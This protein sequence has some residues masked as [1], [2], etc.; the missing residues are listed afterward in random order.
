[1]T[2]RPVIDPTRALAALA[3]ALAA[4]PATAQTLALDWVDSAAAGTDLN[5]SGH[6]LGTKAVWPCGDVHA[7]APVYQP[8]V[9]RGGLRHV[10]PGL[11]GQIGRAHV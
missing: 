2:R 9:W 6:V 4:L 8:S 3:C 11:A 1:M 10:L 5:A 7:C